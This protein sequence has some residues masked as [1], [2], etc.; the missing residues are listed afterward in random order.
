MN[1]RAFM[2]T[3]VAASVSPV[4]HATIPAGTVVLTMDDAVKSH[5]TFAGPLLKELG[6]SARS[7]LPTAGCPTPNTS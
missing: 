2:T 3:A 4:L 5:R 6:H 1:R 7:S